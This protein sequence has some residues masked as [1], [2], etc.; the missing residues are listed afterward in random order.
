MVRNRLTP[1][2]QGF[3]LIELL[4][5][6][7]IIAIL[8]ALLLPAVQQAREAARRSQCRNNLKQVG[9]ALAN[10]H[11]V[12]KVFPLGCRDSSGTWGPSFWVGLLPYSDS[13][14]LFKKMQ[15]GGNAPGWTGA[16]GGTAGDYN[17]QQCNG[18]IQQTLVCPSSPLPILDGNVGGGYQIQRAH[19]V[20]VAGALNGDGLTGSDT[21]S[22]ANSNGGTLS[23]SGMLIPNRGN[24]VQDCTDGLSTT[25]MVSEQA[26]FVLDAAG[27]NPIQVNDNHGWLMGSTNGGSGANY[28]NGGDRCF[29]IT[30]IN[31]R[32]NGIRQGMAGVCNNDGQNN[33]FFAAHTGGVH[34][35]MGDGTVRFVNNNISMFTFRVIS[36]R[37][38]GKVPGEL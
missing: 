1:K 28:P 8:I 34:V 16:G 29:N 17:G 33:G 7:A 10:Y 36:N 21:R 32:P 5:V 14:A 37:N 27:N 18:V 30:T 11:D 24:R 23:L 19:Y 13:A 31:Y 9:L 3:T 4:V 12:A 6:I 22:I 26:N 15:F 35:L 2:R 25:M 20:G 38:D